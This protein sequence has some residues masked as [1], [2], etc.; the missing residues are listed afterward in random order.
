MMKTI[1]ARRAA[2]TA[3]G[4]H[5]QGAVMIAKM[6]GKKQLR[7]KVGHSLFIAVR[8]QMVSTLHLSLEYWLTEVDC[9]LHGWLETTGTWNRLVDY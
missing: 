7:T 3:W 9:E 8:T 6:R 4:S 2:V 1:L 5:I